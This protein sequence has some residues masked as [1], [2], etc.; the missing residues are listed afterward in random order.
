MKFGLIE[1][2][3]AALRG[4][5]LRP[6]A[7]AAN[8][9]ELRSP[10]S[11]SGNIILTM[12]A[13]LPASGTEVVTI[14]NTGQLG[15]TPAAGGGSVTSVAI[16][17]PA[18]L[19]VTGSPITTSG[20]ITLA[21]TSQTA[22]TF[23]GAPSGANGVPSYRAL[24]ALDIPTLLAAS[25]SNFDTQVRVSRLDQ[26]AAPTATVSLNSQ[27][28][29]GLA[30]PIGSQDAATRGFVEATAAGNSNQGAARVASTANITIASPGAAI[31]GVTLATGELVLLKDQTTG[32]QNGLYVWNG[33]AVAM[34]RATNA[35]TSAEVRP[36]MYVFVSE[37]T[38]NGDNGYR[39]TTDDPIVLGTTALVFTQTSGAGQILA[40]TG[41]TKTGNSIDVIGTA[42]RITVAADSVDIASTYVGQASITTLG[43]ITAGVWNG[44]PIP[45]ANGGTG[46][47]TPA[48]ARTALVVPGIFRQS[49]TNASLTA[50][51]LTVTHNLGS[52]IVN[53]QVYDEVNKMVHPD[54]ITLTSSSVLTVDLTSFGNIPS[55]FNCVVTG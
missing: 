32:S 25:I 37:G 34:T 40:G 52:L 53:V 2:M 24:A 26:M 23:L 14:S 35:D 19:S 36:G 43:T 51:I 54:D 27:R 17:T 48:A 31:D 5:R 1:V 30:D 16:A 6:D 12:P 50:G 4:I 47:A 55:T 18:D 21:R 42:N 45:V 22:N 49:F 44:T 33:A 28:I 29:I 38:A 39:L 8:Y 11:L 3:A 15:R 46:A 41:L 9:V 7:G 10:A 20:T 13:S